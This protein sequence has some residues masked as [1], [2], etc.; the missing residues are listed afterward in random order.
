[1]HL[2]TQLRIL[3]VNSYFDDTSPPTIRVPSRIFQSATSV[4]LVGHIKYGQAKSNLHAINSATLTHL[5]LDM[6]QE[7]NL[8]EPQSPFY[9]GRIISLGAISGVLA[10][11]TGHCTALQTLVF[12]RI[13]HPFNGPPWNKATEIASFIEWASFIRSVEGTVRYLTIEL[14]GSWEVRT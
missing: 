4:R 5:C 13:G 10:P 6:L 12:R 14:F 1:M 8:E 11:L 2:L 7:V 9:A 3:D